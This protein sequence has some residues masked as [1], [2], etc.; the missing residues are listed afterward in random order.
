M[1]YQWVDDDVDDDDGG[2]QPPKAADLPAPA[3]QHMRKVEKERDELK[4][5]LADIVASQRTVTVKSVVEAKGYDPRIAAFIPPSIETSDE[6]IGKWLGEYADVFAVKKTE[7][8]DS[9]DAGLPPD[10]VAAMQQMSSVAGNAHPVTKPQDLMAQLNAA[11][12]PEKLNA[13]LRM[14]GAKI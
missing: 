14:N 3:R 8:S 6:A 10:M 12:T 7:S 2:Q 1:G 5:Q 4:K 13:L 11:D 9:D